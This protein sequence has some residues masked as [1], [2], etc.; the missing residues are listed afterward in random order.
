MVTVT[1]IEIDGRTAIGVIVELPGTRLLAVT[2]GRGYIMCGAL[3]VHLLNTRLAERRIIAG[4]ALGV[5]TLE[6]L[7]AA[8][9]ADVTDAA[10]E[11]GIRPGMS[12]REA[13]ALLL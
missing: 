1:P 12:G 6:E 7:L 10:R 2:T 13:V 3:D 4:R 5:R 8:P 9:L 11:L